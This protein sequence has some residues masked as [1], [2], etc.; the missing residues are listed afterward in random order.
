MSDTRL[1]PERI[2]NL[3]ARN[4]AKRTKWE[5][6]L[7]YDLVRTNAIDI[8][9][10]IAEAPEPGCP[11][12]GERANKCKCEPCGEVA[13]WKAARALVGEPTGEL[14]DQRPKK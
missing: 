2:A 12:C 7:E 1:D 3:L 5:K 14:D 11:A 6:Q 8:V 4:K 13:W 10:A 9:K